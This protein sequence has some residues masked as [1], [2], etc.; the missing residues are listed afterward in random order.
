VRE[1]KGIGLQGALERLAERLDRKSGGRFAQEAI[2]DAWRHVA[3]DSV[4]AHT[5]GTHLRDGELV[6]FVDSPVWATELSALAGP[7]REAL[8]AAV[9][10]ELVS[11]I[12]FSVSRKV[13]AERTRVEAERAADEEQS[14]DKVP[15]I[16]LTDQERDQVEASAAVIEDEELREAVIRATVADLQW[17]KGLKAAKT[18]QK[19]PQSL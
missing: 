12:R 8:N 14:E 17:K 18:P 16:A 2:I 6:I 10:Q 7:Y 9:G 11:T 5:T 1:K 3:G 19:P 13:N 4:C 15:S